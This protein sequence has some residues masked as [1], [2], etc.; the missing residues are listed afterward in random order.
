MQTP[1][2][3]AGLQH[4]SLQ[5]GRHHLDL[6]K[7]QHGVGEPTTTLRMASTMQCV[8]G[9]LIDGMRMPFPNSPA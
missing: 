4:Q 6:L 5:D 1:Q 7:V 8:T 9:K 3:M 2:L